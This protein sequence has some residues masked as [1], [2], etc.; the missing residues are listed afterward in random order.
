MRGLPPDVFEV[1][2]SGGFRDR[3]DSRLEARSRM[4]EIRLEYRLR[5]G[6]MDPR[7]LADFI[8]VLVGG[9]V[10][11]WFDARVGADE[12]RR[13]AHALRPH[14][15]QLIHRAMEGMERAGRS[16]HR[17]ERGRDDLL[18]IDPLPFQREWLHLYGD[19]GRWEGRPEDQKAKERARQL[20]MRNLDAGQLRSFKADGSF[21]VTAKGGEVYTIK[22]ARSFNVVAADG[23]SYCG[24]TADT[25]VEDQ[26]LA[27]K[28]LLQSDPDA[29]FK[30]ANVS[31]PQ[32]AVGQRHFVRGFFG[33]IDPAWS[34]R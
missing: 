18:W 24:Q 15:E 22:T 21:R 25:P 20:L 28:L 34:E 11:S 23:T 16:R 2:L 26:M 30:N 9:T 8:E 27:Q 3:A 32:E 31:S 1:L 10:R 17:M 29:F 4:Y 12:G 19:F 7:P 6:W 14:W 5:A 33:G 13:M